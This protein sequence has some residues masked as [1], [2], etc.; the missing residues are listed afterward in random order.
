[1]PSDFA[2]PARELESAWRR[3]PRSHERILTCRYSRKVARDNTVS[4]PGR[5]I[6]LPARGRGRSWQGASVEIREGL[7]GTVHVL[8]A[9]QLITTQPWNDGPFTLVGRIGSGRAL[10]KRCDSATPRPQ[11]VPAAQPVAPAWQGPHQR[12]LAR[13][14][15]SE[16]PQQLALVQL[17]RDAVERLR[18][19]EGLARVVHADDGHDGAG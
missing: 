11:P 9:G 3:T 8:R 18:G 15:G 19:A 10:H 5:W 4:L 7:D 1:M 16:Q 17:E 6:Q 2:K 13:T 14:V 12:G